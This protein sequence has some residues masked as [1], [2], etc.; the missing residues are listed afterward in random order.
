MKNLVQDGMI[1]ELAAPAD[2]LPGEI[3][4][5]G[6][7]VGI[8]VGAALATKPVRVRLEGVFDNLPLKSGDTFSAGAL[9]YYDAA[10]DELTTTAGSNKKFGAALGGGKFRLNGAF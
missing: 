7:I 10:N 9:V 5:V 3:V 8:A 4:C 2:R 6:S 1:I